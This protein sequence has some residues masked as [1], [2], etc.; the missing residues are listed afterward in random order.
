MAEFGEMIQALNLG[1]LVSAPIE[2]CVAGAEEANNATLEYVH[3]LTLDNEH[4]GLNSKMN[5]SFRDAATGATKK[6]SLPLFSLLPESVCADSSLF[7][8]FDVLSVQFTY[9][10]VGS[11]VPRTITVPLLALV[12][13]PYLKIEE[14]ILRFSTTVSEVKSVVG[15]EKTSA[16]MKGSFAAA[17]DCTAVRESRYNVMPTIDF[18]ITVS[19]GDVPGGISKML[20]LL[21]GAVTV[22]DA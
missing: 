14:A 16:E 13:V 12:P 21:G 10:D 17:K 8:H 4:R 5:F 7:S 1:D 22:T 20:D 3:S 11:S 9:Q 2:A 18:N 15:T 6:L 19:G